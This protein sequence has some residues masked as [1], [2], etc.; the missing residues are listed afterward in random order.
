MLDF[1]NRITSLTRKFCLHIF[2]LFFFA[3]CVSVPEATSEFDIVLGDDYVAPI[4]KYSEKKLPAR[5]L[6]LPVQTNIEKSYA[7]DFIVRF[8][9]EFRGAALIVPPSWGPRNVPPTR[10]E[11]ENLAMENNCDLILFMKLLQPSPYP[12][13]QLVVD[14]TLQRVG[15]DMV[16]WQGVADYDTSINRVANSARRYLQKHLNKA[17]T[18]D[19][20]LNILRNN[21]LFIQF[22]AWHLGQHLN[23]LSQSA[24]PPPSE[25]PKPA[26]TQR[27]RK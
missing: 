26:E 7:N 6:F 25:T 16:Y 10:L 19:K 18:P 9:N 12:P 23:R 21:R 8:T 14:I 4:H 11:A 27:N 17:N 13:L 24:P 2:F 20:S 1:K 3:G 15:D 5:I 22:T